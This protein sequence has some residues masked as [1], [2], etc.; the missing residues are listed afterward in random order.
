MVAE[1]VAQLAIT[2]V[3]VTKVPQRW[4]LSWRRTRRVPLL[5]WAGG[6]CNPQHHGLAAAVDGRFWGAA[7]QCWASS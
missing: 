4:R 2:L 6:A 5:R 3:A 1:V 7:R